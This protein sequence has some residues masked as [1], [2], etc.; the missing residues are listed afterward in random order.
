MKSS[1]DIDAC[2]KGC[3]GDCPNHVLEVRG[4]GA[5]SSFYY[6]GI[7]GSMTAQ[8]LEFHA[9]LGTE[10][11]LEAGVP[12][13]HTFGD[14]EVGY[15][16]SRLKKNGNIDLT[17]ASVPKFNLPMPTLLSL[18]A[19][20]VRVALMKADYR[21]FASECLRQF[22]RAIVL[23]VSSFIETVWCNRLPQKYQT[24][25]MSLQSMCLRK[26]SRYRMAFGLY[27]KN[28]W[29]KTEVG[30]PT[31]ISATEGLYDGHK[32]VDAVLKLNADTHKPTEAFSEIAHMAPD[33]IDAMYKKMGKTL[34][35]QE[36]KFDLRDLKRVKLHASAGLNKGLERKSVIDD[37]EVRVS[38]CGQKFDIFQQDVAAIYDFIVSGREPQIYWN[39][40]PKSEVFTASSK[41][42][43]DVKFTAWRNKVRTFVVP[44]SV[45]IHMEALVSP[46]RQINDRGGMNCIGMA[47]CHGGMDELAKKLGATLENCFKKLW[48]SGDISAFDHSV[49]AF[50]IEMYYS[51]MQIYERP[52]GE[53]YEVR[54]RIAKFL[55]KTLLNRVV[56]LLGEIWG[57]QRGGVPS[58]MLNTSSIDTWV[59]ILY[60]VWFCLYTIATA[61]EVIQDRLEAYFWEVLRMAG[62][63]DDQVYFKGETK[64]LRD[65]FS[66]HAFKRF[67]SKFFGVDLRDEE[68]DQPF[69]SLVRNGY[70]TDAG[71]VF[72]KHFAVLNESKKSNQPH[73]LPYRETFD[74]VAKSVW[75]RQAKQRDA[76]DVILSILGH[77]YGTYASNYDA[78]ISLRLF[79]EELI[80]SLGGETGDIME[81]VRSRITL[82]DLKRL[83]QTGI[84]D[85]EILRGFPT[86]EELELRNE[87]QPGYHKQSWKMEENVEDDYHFTDGWDE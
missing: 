26:V 74:Y 71:Q 25:V 8:I 86:W 67:L 1:F 16:K 35:Q 80:K 2:K 78:Y 63:G 70:I 5:F 20:E 7:K 56:H 3:A 73:F 61:D 62:Y 12:V 49:K 72:L 23:P 41:Q 29:D 4:K 33:V 64:D 19:P 36:S 79:Y 28:E 30:R 21:Y 27:R 46:N 10:Y 68:D 14:S 65:Y 17:Y 6:K 58:G 45:F 18:P 57:V 83:R 34:G 42:H 40:V 51:T 75:G 82:A 76:F 69:C 39:V 43:C 60:W 37:E 38:P 54:K 59:M 11:R 81:K 55:S 50:L 52:G 87:L 84:T 13:L 48:A 31:A 53:N 44:S 24:E 85:R 77:A 32:Y 47:W 22:G 66:I 9:K 15:F